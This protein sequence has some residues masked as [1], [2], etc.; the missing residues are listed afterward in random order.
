MHEESLHNVVREVSEKMK[1][2]GGGSGRRGGAG[3][4]GMSGVGGED[5]MDIDDLMTG[6]VVEGSRGKKWK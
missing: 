1:E 3:A 2:R 6:G 5:R 4:L